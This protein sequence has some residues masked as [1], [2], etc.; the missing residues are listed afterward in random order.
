M[1][2][3]SGCERTLN[4]VEGCACNTEY[5][6]HPL[7]ILFIVLIIVGICCSCSSS[8]GSSIGVVFLDLM[9]KYSAEKTT[10]GGCVQCV[11]ITNPDSTIIY[12]CGHEPISESPCK[13]TNR[14]GTW[15][16]CYT[17]L[18]NKSESDD[19]D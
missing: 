13:T 17:D 9:G 15:C 8:I 11:T 14:G 6:N 3:E 10:T 5:C 4:G 18:C 1:S 16:Y 2:S 7:H 19:E 12:A